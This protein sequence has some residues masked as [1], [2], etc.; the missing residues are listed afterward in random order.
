MQQ[1]QWRLILINLESY[2]YPVTGF[3][4][5]K[6]C[7]KF[8]DIVDSA[9]FITKILIRLLWINLWTVLITCGNSNYLSTTAN[10]FITFMQLI[11]NALMVRIPLS[12]ILEGVARKSDSVVLR[13]KPEGSY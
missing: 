6:Q 1:P 13:A 3:F 9:P 8:V 5:N 7:I 11:H 10:G 4:V 2:V 12:A